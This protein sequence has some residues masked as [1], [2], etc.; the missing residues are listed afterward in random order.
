[1]TRCR[2]CDTG[3]VKFCAFGESNHPFSDCFHK[4]I[5]PDLLSPN[6]HE[7]E[8]CHVTW[9]RQGVFLCVKESIYIL[10]GVIHRNTHTYI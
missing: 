4:Q 6:E 3:M 8:L 5:K 2:C 7:Y 10:H 1:M 9:T